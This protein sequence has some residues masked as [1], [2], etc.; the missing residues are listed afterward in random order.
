[1]IDSADIK[2]IISEHYEQLYIQKV[3][4]LGEMNKFL[5]KYKLPQLIQYEIDNWNH[6]ITIKEMQFII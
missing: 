3:G 2:R 5:E 1:M 6:L 4:N